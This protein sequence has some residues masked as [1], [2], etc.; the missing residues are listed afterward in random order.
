MCEPSWR[1]GVLTLPFSCT[2]FFVAVIMGLVM[3]FIEGRRRQLSRSTLTDFLLLALIGGVIGGRL[4][5]AVLMD[6]TYYFEQPLRLIYIQDCG[7]SFW[8]GFTCAFV[9]LSFWAYHRDLIAERYLDT[10][11]PALA[12]CLSLGYIGGHVH[13][14]IVGRSLPWALAVEGVQRHPDGVYAIVLL[15]VLYLILKR[16][17]YRSAYEGELFLIFLLGYSVINI[18]LD[19]IRD[20]PR[21]W[22]IFTAGQLFSAVVAVFTLYLIVTGPRTFIS[23]VYLRRAVYRQGPVESAVFYLWHLLL[24][25]GAVWFYYWI[26][27]PL[28]FP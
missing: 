9:M 14:M 4:V 6:Y 8:G 1:C 12:F 3:T 17:R 5:Y 18:A 7:F 16:R 22:G 28:M 21:I 11:A 19:F 24:T 25:A 27:R 20:L 2:T 23:T 13:G 10:A 15:M 26:R